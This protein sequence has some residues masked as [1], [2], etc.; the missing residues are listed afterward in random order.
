M[1]DT[2]T[3]AVFGLMN[4][5]AAIWPLDRPDAMSAST[6]RPRSVRPNGTG[7]SLAA[8][9]APGTGSPHGRRARAWAPRRSLP[10]P[11][12]G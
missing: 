4:S 3:L 10:V 2:W 11:V 8:A 5:A 7:C 9:A 1:L 12:D 6:S